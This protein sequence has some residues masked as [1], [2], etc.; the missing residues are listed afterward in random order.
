MNQRKLLLASFS[1]PDI[2]SLPRP[3][4]GGRWGAPFFGNA[5]HRHREV[6]GRVML[7]A[8]MHSID[9]YCKCI[10]SHRRK[11]SMSTYRV[12]TAIS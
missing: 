12:L 2:A 3:E 5:L 4:G 9:N 7:T 6:V 10:I 11:H 8:Q 1:M